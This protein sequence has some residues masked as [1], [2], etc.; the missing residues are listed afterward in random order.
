MRPYE[1][2]HFDTVTSLAIYQNSI[3]S[4]SRDKNLRRWDLAGETPY[5]TVL[6]AH[7]DWVNH[8][9]VSF[10]GDC[11][12]SAG[13]EGKIRV[14]QDVDSILVCVGEVPGHA[15]SVNCL[16]S[17]DGRHL[18]SGG[19]DKMIKIWKMNDDD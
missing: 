7:N 11:V 13:K 17:L 1:P 19:T 16:V 9:G 12:Y 4:G 15:S 5:P 8:L 18:I 2:P 10:E 14:W 3:V 6:T